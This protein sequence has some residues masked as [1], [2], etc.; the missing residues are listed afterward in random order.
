[1]VYFSFSNP[2]L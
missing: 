1:M 2:K